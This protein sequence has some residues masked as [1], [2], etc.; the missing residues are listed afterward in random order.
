MSALALDVVE[1]NRSRR[2]ELSD[3]PADTTVGE[4]LSEISEAMALGESRYHL[5]YEGQRLHS[6][7]TLDEIGIEAGDEVTIAPEVS[8]G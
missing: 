3:V 7:Q 2:A 4:L 1:W 6:H 5:I 8:A